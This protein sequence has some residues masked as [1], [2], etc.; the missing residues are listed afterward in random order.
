M[1]LRIFEAVGK[2][3]AK[4]EPWLS[5]LAA[6]SFASIF[7]AMFLAPA[8]LIP[9]LFL[10]TMWLCGLAMVSRL[11]SPAIDREGIQSPSRISRAPMLLRRWNVYLFAVWW[12]FMIL[13]TVDLGLRALSNG[14]LPQL[15]R[16]E[17][18]TRNYDVDKGD[19]Q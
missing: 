15:N 18:R 12:A 11:F 1:L 10:L 4:G 6:V 9:P 3:V 5:I 2:R 14:G 7:F 19:R 13:F 8:T 16:V 17:P